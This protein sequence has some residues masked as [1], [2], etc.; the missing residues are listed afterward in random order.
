MTKVLLENEKGDGS[1]LSIP[2]ES[3]PVTLLVFVSNAD[4]YIQHYRR[5]VRQSEGDCDR[6]ALS[7]E[8]RKGGEDG[9][10]RRDPP[11]DSRASGSPSGP[12][13]ALPS[14]LL[15]SFSN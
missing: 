14:L 6:T 7:N 11:T 3:W 9:R 8:G 1:H 15:S 12:A 5:R 4:P 13:L 10:R 2:G